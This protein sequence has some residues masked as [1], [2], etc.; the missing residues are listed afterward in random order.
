MQPIGH[1]THHTADEVLLDFSAVLEPIRLHDTHR[2]ILLH[3][4][5]PLLPP[6]RHQARPHRR[7]RGCDLQPAAVTL[8]PE[9]DVLHV[10]Q[11]F[12]AGGYLAALAALPGVFGIG[13]GPGR[14]DIQG[15]IDA[16]LGQIRGYL[17]ILGRL[18]LLLVCEGLVRKHV[19]DDRT[20][21]AGRERS[22]RPGRGQP[23][24]GVFACRLASREGCSLSRLRSSAAGPPGRSTSPPWPTR[25]RPSEGV[26][27]HQNR[28]GPR[29]SRGRPC[30]PP[31]GVRALPG[32]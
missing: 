15:V 5:D 28:R 3:E 30:R 9:L 10:R 31:A 13:R 18:A 27:T 6:E 24:D 25:A 32:G 21:A 11:N 12:P 26:V 23:S 19:I 7:G 8:A 20:A 29:C 16:A 22:A 1:L 14:R 17:Q 4:Q 2:R